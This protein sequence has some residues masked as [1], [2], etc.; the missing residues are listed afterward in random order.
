MNK[1]EL[2]KEIAFR[3]ALP[4]T[5]T[6]RF[7]DTMNE[8]ISD[9]ITREESVLIQNFGHYMP[10]EQAERMGRNPRTGQECMIRKR[11]SVKFKP[12]KGLIGKI[13]EK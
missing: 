3:M 9:S 7:I 1:I 6:L 5:E 4:V 13:N 11:V 10:W 8:V 2:A 12:G